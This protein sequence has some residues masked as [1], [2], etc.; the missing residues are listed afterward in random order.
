MRKNKK[1]MQT[2]FKNKSSFI[3]AM[4]FSDIK[5]LINVNIL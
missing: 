3:P 1:I 5:I 2:V 4:Y